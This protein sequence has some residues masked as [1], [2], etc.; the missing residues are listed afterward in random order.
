L[1]QQ[2][3]EEL[4]AVACEGMKGRV[5][6]HK[7]LSVVFFDLLKTKYGIQRFFFLL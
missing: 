2:Q 7:K 1:L 5:L 3:T 6:E 4:R